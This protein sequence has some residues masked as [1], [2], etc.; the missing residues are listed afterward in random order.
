V[1][2]ALTMTTSSDMGFSFLILGLEVFFD[3]G[4][5]DGGPVSSLYPVKL[6]I[7]CQSARGQNPAATHSKWRLWQF[8]EQ[9]PCL[10]INRAA[11]N[12]SRT[13]LKMLTLLRCVA[14][15]PAGDAVGFPALRVDV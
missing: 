10:G 11:Q 9:C 5:P 3:G 15:P 8:P 4:R 6:G 2:A 1:R 13:A 14:R 7:K 12:G